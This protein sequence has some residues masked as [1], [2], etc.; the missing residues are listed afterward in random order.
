MDNIA[1]SHY[2]RHRLADA[3]YI[4]YIKFADNLILDLVLCFHDH[5]QQSPERERILRHSSSRLGRGVRGGRRV[6]WMV[7]PSSRD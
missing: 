1:P 6:V 3:A 5:L 2:T 7:L 4:C